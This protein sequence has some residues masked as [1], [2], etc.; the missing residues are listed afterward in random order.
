MTNSK[1]FYWLKLKENFFNQKEIKKLRKI[2]GGDTFTI[3]YLKMQL[4]SLRNGGILKYEG[5]EENLAE[6]LSYEIDEDVDNIQVTINFLIKNKLLEV[7]NEDEY[8]LLKASENI[9]S[10]SESAERVRKF[11]EKKA[12]QCNNDVTE[13]NT[14]IDIDIEIDKDIDNNISKDILSSAEAQQIVNR[15]NSLGLQKLVSINPGSNRHKMLKARIK[16]YGLENVLKAIESIN[17]SSFLKGQNNRNWIITFDW[18]IRP[19]NF[20]KVLEGNYLDKGGNNNGPT[21]GDSGKNFKVPKNNYEE[22]DD[23]GLI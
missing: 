21:G 1:K 10:E 5:T 7:G 3:I 11:R 2:A 4:I 18:L 8:L 13:S 16:E 19:N 22:T 15:W 12:L 17:N 23:S 14:E 9:G 20:P 6:Q